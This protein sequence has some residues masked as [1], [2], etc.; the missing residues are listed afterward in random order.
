MIWKDTR[1]KTRCFSHILRKIFV[2]FPTISFENNFLSWVSPPVCLCVML[3][4]SHKKFNNNIKTDRFWY[5][6]LTASDTNIMVTCHNRHV[7]GE[8]HNCAIGKYIVARKKVVVI[9][10]RAK[11]FT[12]PACSQLEVTVFHV[13]SIIWI[14][15]NYCGQPCVYTWWMNI[16]LN[17]LPIGGDRQVHFFG[18]IK[19]VLFSQL[20]GA[21]ILFMMTELEP[22]KKWAF[23]WAARCLT[24]ER[25]EK[26]STWL[27]T[28]CSAHDTRVS[29]A[30]GTGS[31][32]ISDLEFVDAYEVQVFKFGVLKLTMRHGDTSSLI[33]M[34]FH[35]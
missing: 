8:R 28:K 19:T 24:S 29:G 1:R 6:F 5:H 35:K 27:L 34:V 20:W 14:S 18:A 22:Q 17:I 10:N 25:E 11:V 12:H 2:Y 33:A 31:F 32:R 30:V 9:L 21:F 15:Q 26:R 3:T 13:Q 7:E 23:F 16:F 4:F